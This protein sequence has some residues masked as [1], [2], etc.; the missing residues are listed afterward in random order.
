MLRALLIDMDGT[1][2]ESEEAHRGAFNRAFAE[3]GLPYAWDEALYG[4][5]L[6]VKGGRDRLRHFLETAAPRPDDPAGLAVTLHALKTDLFAVAVARGGLKP[7]PGVTRLMAEA[8]RRGVRLGLVTSATRPTAA[9]L[10][11]AVLGR[12]L[13][14]A[15]DAAATGDRVEANKPA[16]DLYRLALADL[17]LA[18]EACVAIEDDGAGLAAATG[19]GIAT[20]VT[21]SAYG[22]KSGFAGALAV[23][24]DLEAGPEGPVT[25]AW[26]EGRLAA[27]PSEGRTL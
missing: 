15:F 11:R 2:C 27:A 5:L 7:R 3:A 23:V 16:P 24:P 1:L 21:P 20:L 4:R 25:L 9:P 14:R 13:D 12:E 26:L 22:P 19:A 6:A 17:A 8:R 18:P 10:V